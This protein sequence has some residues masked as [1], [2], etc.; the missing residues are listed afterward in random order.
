MPY[1]CKI[2]ADSIGPSGVR[3]TTMELSYPRFVHAEF[4]THRMFS[5]NAQSNRAIPVLKLIEA[6]ESDPVYPVEWGKNQ[7]GMQARAVLSEREENSARYLWRMARNKAI[8]TV[9]DLSNLG[10]HKQIANRLLEPFQWIRV[11]VSATEYQNFFKLRCHPDAQPEIR[12]IA[13]MMRDAYHTNQP[14]RV[15]LRDW[16]LPYITDADRALAYENA[17]AKGVAEGDAGASTAGQLVTGMAFGIAT[18]RKVSVARVARVSYLNHDGKRDI[19]ADLD[20]HDKLSQS[21]HW[22]PF[23]H[24]AQALAQPTQI[25]NFQGWKQYRKTFP[26]E[27]G[28]MPLERVG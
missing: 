19:Q 7:P 1:E 18:L 25:G 12:H 20:L 15:T 27:S 4:M 9:R 13:S 21:G 14:S 17:A 26:E 5:R 6:V 8:E 23:E 11:I 10:T 3:L 16:H 22:S 28:T 24:V 2:I